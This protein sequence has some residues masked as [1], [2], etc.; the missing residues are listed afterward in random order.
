MRSLPAEERFPAEVG[1][2]Y[3]RRH[4]V[5]QGWL[6]DFSA[7]AIL[8]LARWQGARGIRGPVAEIGVH[9]G[10][11][12][13]LL[14]LATRQGE[15]AIAVDLFSKQHLNV[16]G[17]GR[18]DKRIFLRH[19]DRIA[20]SR[21]GL[22]LIED[23]SFNVTPEQLAAHGKLRLFSIDGS[24]TE[25]ATLNDLQ[26]ADATLASEGIV[27]VDD[28]FNESWPEVSGA[29]AKYLA[30]GT[31]VPFA[32]TP[33]KVLLCR[34][35]MA[36]GYQDFLRERFARRVD[37]E[38]RLYGHHVLVVGV[39]PWTTR[40]AIGTTKLGAMLKRLRARLQ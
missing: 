17:S 19:V 16:D 15:A 24:H 32:I 18:G 6:S 14:Y 3:L 25:A 4:S 33:G 13:L 21:D 7:Q 31:L 1:D 10:K 8:A 28:C 5:V 29:L 30:A 22:A 39:R 12:F 40:R 11:L 35:P 34:G 38:A 27:I 23:S 9:H 20:G 26:L 2:G 37:K 36:A